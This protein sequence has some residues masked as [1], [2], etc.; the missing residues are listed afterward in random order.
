MPVFLWLVLVQVRQR[1][2]RRHGV[3]VLGRAA[4]GKAV[5]EPGFA[6]LESGLVVREGVVFVQTVEPDAVG[7]FP[8]VPAFGVDYTSVGQGHEELARVVGDGDEVMNEKLDLMVDDIRVDFC[9]DFGHGCGW[10]LSL[11]VAFKMLASIEL[12]RQDDLEEK[13]RIENSVFYQ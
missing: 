6:H 1:Q 12:A 3:D 9:E 7:P 10:R 5:A 8:V 2:K 11:V 4:G 13:K